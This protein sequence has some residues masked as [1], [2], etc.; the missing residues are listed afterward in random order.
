MDPHSVRVTGT[1]LGDLSWGDL[2]RRWWRPAVVVVLMTFAIV[3]RLVRADIG[4]PPNLELVTA[5]AFAAALLLR[6]RVAAFVPLAVTIV[7]DLVL[8]NSSVLWFVWATW[9]VIGLSAV[10]LPRWTGGR[11]YVAALGFGVGG[12]L[13]F[14][15]A[16]NFGVWFLGRGSWYADSFDGLMA[17]YVAGLPFLRTMLLGNLVLVPAAAGVVTLVERWERTRALAATPA[18]AVSARGGS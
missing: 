18:T 6:N 5:A 14:Y 2:A 8:G 4:A 17:S 1:R 9:A 16:T 3:W 10:L 15:L 13:F 12:S 11:R 7:S